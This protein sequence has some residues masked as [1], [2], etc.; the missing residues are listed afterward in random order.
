MEEIK[1]FKIT[2]TK[3]GLFSSGGIGPGW[4]KRGKTWNNIGH[5][6]NHLR[7]FI[8][9][10]RKYPEQGWKSEY[11]WINKIP[12]SWMVVEMSSISGVKQYSARELMP[13]TKPE[14]R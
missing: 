6:K 2:D 10:F 1:I 11:E 14:K 7:Q 9:N 3:T 13:L 8:G 12:D 4:S 5:V